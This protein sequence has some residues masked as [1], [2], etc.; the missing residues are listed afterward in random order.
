MDNLR[1]LLGIRRMNRVPNAQ[2]RE[3]CR[4]TKGIDEGILWWFIHVERMENDRI[5]KC[6]Y[7]RVCAGSRSVSRPQ[8]RWINT[9]RLF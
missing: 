9:E 5:D 8:K 3:L 6:V 7:V 1:H 2:I 4:V